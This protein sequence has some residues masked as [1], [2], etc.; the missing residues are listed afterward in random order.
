MCIKHDAKRNKITR[1]FKLKDLV[2]VKIPRIDLA[3]AEFSRIPA[4]IFKV[5]GSIDQF[6]QLL[7][8]HGILKDQYRAGDLEKFC[9]LVNV[10]YENY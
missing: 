3:S 1:D 5:S 9:G 4:M 10:N 7:T 8:E 2:S 6:Y